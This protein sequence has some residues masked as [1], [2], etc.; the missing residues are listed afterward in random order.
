MRVRARAR[1]LRITNT[2]QTLAFMKNRF[3]GIQNAFKR[4]FC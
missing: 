4:V 2:A 3:K 1:A